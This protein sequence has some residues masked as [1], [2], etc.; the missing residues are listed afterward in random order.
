M[1]C[2]KKSWLSSTLHRP[3]D[4]LSD[5]P[6]PPPRPRCGIMGENCPLGLVLSQVN[7]ASPSWVAELGNAN[8]F[9]LAH[10][11]KAENITRIDP[12]VCLMTAKSQKMEPVDYG[13]LVLF[14]EGEKTSLDCS[15]FNALTVNFVAISNLSIERFS[16][17]LCTRMQKHG[18]RRHESVYATTV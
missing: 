11:S 13:L 9:G 8:W 6:A 14:S 1:H 16:F 3:T 15:Y 7:Q 4:P 5:T 2:V 17:S 10:F 18:D 12:S